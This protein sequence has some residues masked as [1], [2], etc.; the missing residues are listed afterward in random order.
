MTSRDFCYWLQG[1]FEITKS[2]QSLIELTSDQVDMIQKHLNLVFAHEI[3]PSMGNPE[4][5]SQL[6]SI[7]SNRPDSAIVRC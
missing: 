7:H 1:F 5:Q 3:D 4:H 2:N 6:N